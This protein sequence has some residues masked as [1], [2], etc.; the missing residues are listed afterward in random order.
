MNTHV[1]SHT[2]WAGKY[3]PTGYCSRVST[4]RELCLQPRENEV[5]AKHARDEML[6]PGESDLERLT[7]ARHIISYLAY[8]SDRST[9]I[10]KYNVDESKRFLSI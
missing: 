9:A 6:T 3:L 10:S 1:M 5:L 8:L 4:I 2:V 7:R